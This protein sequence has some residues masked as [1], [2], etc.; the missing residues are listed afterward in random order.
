MK[1]IGFGLNVTFN[2]KCNSD[3]S[4]ARANMETRTGGGGGW[5][6]DQVRSN[7]Q[8]IPF[9]Y[10]PENRIKVLEMEKRLG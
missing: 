5:G 2:L 3:W 6:F 8:H 9:L 4:R 1:P 7:K 10:F